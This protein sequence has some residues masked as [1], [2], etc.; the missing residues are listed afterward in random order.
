MKYYPKRRRLS[1]LSESIQNRR[2][3][4]RRKVNESSIKRR[5]GLREADSDYIKI[6]NM[7]LP[8]NAA[9]Y[10]YADYDT[11]ANDTRR[12]Y[13]AE[14]EAERKAEQDR[15]AKI[16]ANKLKAKG[17]E[18]Y[19]QFEDTLQE[20]A[21][22]SDEEVL[23]KVFQ[24]MVPSEGAC[25]TE[26]GELVRAMVRLLYRCYND[27]DWFFQDYGLET[28]ASS[29]AYLMEF[30]GNK[31]ASILQD[32]AEQMYDTDEDTY[33]TALKRA[34]SA[35]LNYLED[36]E[37]LFMIKPH[38]NSRDY[39]GGDYDWIQE[40]GHSYEFEI[41]PD[42]MVRA[43]IDE[44]EINDFID[45]LRYECSDSRKVTVDQPYRDLYVLHNLTRWDYENL[46]KNYWRW[47]QDFIEE[48]APEEDEEDW[49]DDEDYEEDED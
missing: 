27:G 44:Y 35:L 34:A 32:R 43:G 21:G 48:N 6:G 3:S 41:N 36:N 17:T 37:E 23:D 49:E 45:N 29:A 39:V 11:V 5:R 31:V 10:G 20:Y 1:H 28:C 14:K 46:D 2:F 16:E 7:M 12:R 18:L 47:E 4:T 15:L 19:N 30:G 25:E 40:I 26:A 24:F 42:E 9:G 13:N 38:D 33:E 22:L 8:K